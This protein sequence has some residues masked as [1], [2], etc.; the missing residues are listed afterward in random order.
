MSAATHGWTVRLSE[1]TP[2][3][4]DRF[5]DGLRAVAMLGVVTGHWFVTGLTVTDHGAFAQRSPLQQMPGLAPA[6]WLL[7]TLG[8]FFFAS[9]FAAARSLA[10]ATRRGHGSGRWWAGRV[11]RL[12]R[13]VAVFV[14]VWAVAL[15]VLATVGMPAQTLHTVGKLAVSPLWFLLVLLV[16]LACTPLLQSVCRRAG[17]WAVAVPVAVVA[18]VD[19]LRFGVWPDLPGSVALVNVVAGWLVPFLIGVLV[20]R[21]GPPPCRVAAG[22]VGVA[23]VVCGLLVLGAGYPASMVGVP[24]SGRSNLDPPSL[25]TVAHTLMQIGLALLVRPLA[26]RLLRRPACWAAVVVLNLSAMTV[27]VWHQTALM[28][29]AGAGRVLA[30]AP[31]GLLDA[32][33]DAAWIVH[34]CAWLPAFL[35]VLGLLWALFRGAERPVRQRRTATSSTERPDMDVTTTRRHGGA[36]TTA[37]LS[38]D[39]HHTPR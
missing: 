32:P 17:A 28:V 18:G 2:A 34:R 1:A 25:L 22:M 26:E 6:T 4:R 10:A 30:G 5:I 11:A 3:G 16:L 15:A 35:L 19:A 27:F 13:P 21:Y 20:A 33:R 36:E 31:P 37:G 9:G 23:V 7:Q 12:V 29:V 24:G 38:G 8:L 14:V 39:M